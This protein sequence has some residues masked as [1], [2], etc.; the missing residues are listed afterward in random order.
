M[1]DDMPGAILSVRNL[2]MRY[3]SRHG[4]VHALNGVDFSVR[5]G[6]TVGLVGESG[7]GK[8]ALTL[9]ALRLL[10]KSAETTD[11]A[12]LFDGKDLLG[13]SESAMRRIRGSGIALI[14]QDP[15]VSLD[16]LFPIGRQIAEALTAHR[17]MSAGEARQRTLELLTK[18]GIP[19][20]ERRIGAYPH[21]LS[22]GM[23]QRVVGAIGVSCAPKVL[24]AD[25]PTTA[26]D[27]TIQAQYLALLKRLQ[28]ET[29]LA[30]VIITHDLSVVAQMCDRVAVMYAGRIVEQAD[31]HTLF[32][33]PRHPYTRA[34]ITAGRYAGGGRM[35][36]IGGEPPKL[37]A[38]PAACSFAPRCDRAIPRCRAELPAAVGLSASHFSACF[39]AAEPMGGIQ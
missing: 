30:L 3:R 10:P 7:C 16:P 35:T 4:A 6:E 39:R 19:D 21:E 2:H 26:L 27:V 33:D 23:R 36:S 11:G 28:A 37:S 24:I 22:G 14:P 31:V 32:D 9:S 25:E 34:L 38:P 8:T 12:I 1:A 29:N 13:C 15:M 18:V 5:S 17:R 20:A